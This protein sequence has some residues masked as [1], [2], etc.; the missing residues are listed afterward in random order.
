MIYS[1]SDPHLSFGAD[2]PMDIFGEKWQ[3]HAEKIRE[4]WE[5]VVKSEDTVLVCG[6]ISWALTRDEAEPDID[7]VANLPGRKILIRGNH[8][9][10]WRRGDFNKLKKAAPPS[11][12]F[13]HGTAEFIGNVGIT[14]TRGWRLEPGGDN[15]NYER[16]LARELMYF[17]RGLEEIKD[18]EYKI[19][20]LHYPPYE[21]D[22]TPNDFAAM[23]EKYGVD[24]LVYGHIHG[25]KAITGDVNGV[26]YICSSADK[27]DFRPLIVY[28]E[29]ELCTESE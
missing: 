2:K 28:P 10:W 13:I 16:V 19:A 29:E 12:T 9:Y 8:D 11:I 27:A 18:A 24:T 15:D 7:F 25:A 26:R 14:G 5:S 1:L 3:G 22:F 20:M 4:N 23:A 6:D 17:R 21:V